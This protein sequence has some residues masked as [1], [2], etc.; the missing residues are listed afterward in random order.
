[1]F[2][3]FVH[4]LKYISIN[5]NMPASRGLKGGQVNARRWPGAAA[6]A[7][8]AINSSAAPAFSVGPAFRVDF[9]QF[10]KIM[11]YSIQLHVHVHVL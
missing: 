2:L 5:F 8:M 4:E 9:G 1:M 10:Y 7:V 3:V 11:Q 6:V